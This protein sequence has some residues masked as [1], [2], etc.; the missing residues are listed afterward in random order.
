MEFALGFLTPSFGYARICIIT[1]SL[2]C[3]D[4]EHFAWG[5]GEFGEFFASYARANG[6]SRLGIRR[7]S[8]SLRSVLFPPVHFT[9]F[10]VSCEGGEGWDMFRTLLALI[11]VARLAH[12]DDGLGY[13]SWVGGRLFSQS[14]VLWRG[15]NQLSWSSFQTGK[16]Y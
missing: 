15:C 13:G 11:I 10:V 9:R 12:T 6:T 16:S 1:H 7:H 4:T 5:S 2:W 14:V 8:S 3:V